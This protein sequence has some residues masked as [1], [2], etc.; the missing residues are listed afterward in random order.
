MKSISWFTSNKAHWIF[1]SNSFVGFASYHF[2]RN[3]FSS[4]CEPIRINAQCYS[5]HFNVLIIY[6]I[7]KLLCWSKHKYL[8]CRSS[9]N[10]VYARFLCT[11]ILLK[12]D[13]LTQQ[14][15]IFASHLQ[16]TVMRVYVCFNTS[17]Q[18]SVSFCLLNNDHFI[19]HIIM[20]LIMRFILRANKLGRVNK[21]IKS[22]LEFR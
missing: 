19:T 15:N 13:Q 5:N 6:T 16:R 20:C 11:V 1:T 21:P 10:N 9:T 12:F 8:I 22:E 14:T 18:N 3:P 2:N 17:K 7:I 4:I